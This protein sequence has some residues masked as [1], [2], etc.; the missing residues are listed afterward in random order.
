MERRAGRWLGGGGEGG[1]G[2]GAVEGRAERRRRGGSG[3]EVEGAEEGKGGHAEANWT[4]PAPAC[5]H[6]CMSCGGGLEPTPFGNRAWVLGGLR[7]QA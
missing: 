2:G 1:A 4:S 5:L 7:R 6:A 3:G